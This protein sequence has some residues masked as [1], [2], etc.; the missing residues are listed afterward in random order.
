MRLLTLETEN[1][2]QER[3][4]PSH[5][6]LKI[7]IKVPPPQAQAYASKPQLS[8]NDMLRD[9]SSQLESANRQLTELQDQLHRNEEDI[10]RR[11]EMLNHLLVEIEKEAVNEWRV[12]Q[13]LKVLKK[14]F[15]LML[16]YQ[17]LIPT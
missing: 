14:M 9:L 12:E 3:C 2:W 8:P 17:S 13:Q 10:R 5:S 11:R 15:S 4:I 6:P 16:E 1:R 7:K